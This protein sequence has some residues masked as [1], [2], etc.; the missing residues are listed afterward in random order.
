MRNFI[1]ASLILIVMGTMFNCSFPCYGAAPVLH[2][3][4]TDNLMIKRERNDWN[5]TLLRK[6]GVG[7][8]AKQST[9]F[10]VRLVD[11]LPTNIHLLSPEPGIINIVAVDKKE[12]PL[13]LTVLPG[14][15]DVK[16]DLHGLPSL[17]EVTKVLRL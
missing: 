17:P 8:D 5:A 16:I 13:N 9:T 10:D 2:V 11:H 1:F 6:I 7:M 3:Q 14:V 4:T 15:N 12:Y